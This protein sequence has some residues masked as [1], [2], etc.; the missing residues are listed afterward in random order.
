MKKHLIFAGGGHAHIYSLT[1]LDR[2]LDAGVDV[3]V[4]SR[5]G[6]HYYSGM[7][8]GLLSGFYSPEETR[9]NVKEIV[10]SFGCRF[11]E[12]GVVK[13]EPGQ[14][15]IILSDN[16]V[17]DYDF[18]SFNTGSEVVPLH[19]SGST[20]NI[21]PVKPLENISLIRERVTLSKE[22]L[23]IAVVGGGAAGVEFA[24]NIRELADS[25][26][27]EADISI[28]S[29]EHILPGYS[30][31]FYKRVL[32]YLKLRKIN[33]YEYKNVRDI[34]QG[35]IL[36]ESGEMINFD[37][38]VNAAGIKPSGIFMR[39]GMKTGEDGGLAVNKY[40]QHTAYPEIFAGGDCITFEPVHLNKVG[41]Y[42]VRQGVYLFN[43][44]LASIKGERPE[45]FKPQREY[46]AILNM[47]FRKG[48]MLWKG[49]VYSGAVPFYFKYYLD[50][51]FMKKFQNIRGAE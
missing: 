12:A 41:V 1:R 5:S 7:G 25:A 4:V 36:F 42:A 37:I 18:I 27:T 51:S 49:R 35:S 50:S 45:E 38:A 8:P 47:G 48:I 24:A 19:V 29:R 20:D 2:F 31:P 11:I 40:L 14:R 43:N 16:T 32:K 22:K 3:T 23:R 6:F 17:L 10:E 33:I 9:F 39:S 13:V 26:E 21:F 15:K 44:L 34:A 28:I 30:E 46:L